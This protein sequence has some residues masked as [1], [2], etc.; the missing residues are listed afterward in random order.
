MSVG[1]H[2]VK[3]GRYPAGRYPQHEAQ[4]I[5][6]ADNYPMVGRD[7]LQFSAGDFLGRERFLEGHLIRLDKEKQE[8]EES[9]DIWYERC[10]KEGRDSIKQDQELQK[11]LDHA[12]KFIAEQSALLGRY[13]EI[14]NEM[15]ETISEFREKLEASRDS[16]PSNWTVDM[17]EKLQVDAKLGALVRAAMKDGADCITISAIIGKQV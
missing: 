15:A 5:L 8:A 17:I 9:R 6:P 16:C 4:E 11:R 12:E 14:K 7:D 2:E 1:T 3:L 13:I 10:L